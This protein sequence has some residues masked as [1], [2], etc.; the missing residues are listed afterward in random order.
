ME[1]FFSFTCLE[2]LGS[3]M[4]FSF[5]QYLCALPSLFV[6]SL[7][8]SYEGD[9]RPS[10]LPDFAFRRVT[11]SVLC[12]SVSSPISSK[13]ASVFLLLLHWI[14]G[15]LSMVA[16]VLHY[17]RASDSSAVFWTCVRFSPG[18]E[19]KQCV[20]ASFRRFFF[21]VFLL[22]LTPLAWHSAS[23]PPPGSFRGD[24]R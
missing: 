10:R 5:C 21:S 9:A 3:G 12:P 14:I 16:P 24:S 1:L 19:K 7:M 22:R 2:F 18:R 23:N 6:F 8:D 11:L 17:R 4:L 13:F 20:L 15:A